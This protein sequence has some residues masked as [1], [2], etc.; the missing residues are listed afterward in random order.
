MS[1]LDPAKAVGHEQG[2]TP[3][4]WT[5]RD[6][7]LYAVGI[8]AGKDDL[9]MVYELDPGF[10]P[11]PTFPVVLGFKGE[12]PDVVD[13][14]KSITDTPKTPGLPSFPPGRIVH[15][16]QSVEVLRP[17]PKVS[18]PGWK[19][20]KR[21]TGVHENK[22]GV[23]VE[24]EILLLDA[25]DVPY[26][27]MMGATFNV[28]GKITGQKF[29]KQIAK[30]ITPSK[31]VPKGT[32]PTATTSQTVSQEQAIIYRLSGDYNPLHI[33]PSI[34]KKAGFGGVIL[35]GLASYGITAV[36]L[37]K[38]LGGGD[39]N[40]LKAISARFTSPVKLGD[41]LEIKAWELGPGPNGTTE[42]AFETINTSTGKPALGGGVVYIQKESK[43]KL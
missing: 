15:G 28:G 18:G 8:G 7:L 35:H 1:D 27:R 16:T 40:S 36:A 25:N 19:V 32:E 3:V 10:T 30:F 21:V 13:F 41:T 39:P 29:S 34:G 31:T 17:I 9:S 11:F 12:N 6:L 37:V 20:K 14:N 43:S 38:I 23:I 22:S 24:T 26:T 42:F 33:E 5:T 2:T 4:A